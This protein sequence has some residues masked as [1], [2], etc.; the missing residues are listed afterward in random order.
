MNDRE[1]REFLAGTRSGLEAGI[2]SMESQVQS[3]CE[4]RDVAAKHIDELAAVC[5]FEELRKALVRQAIVRRDAINESVDQ[6]EDQ[7]VKLKN[8]LKM[9]QEASKG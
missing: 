4:L 5:T 1:M 3:L 7:L 6:L 8:T 2:A 9:S